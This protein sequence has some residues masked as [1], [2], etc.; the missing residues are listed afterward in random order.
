MDKDLMLSGENQL[1]FSHEQLIKPLVSEIHL[2]DTYVANTSL[3]HDKEAVDKLAPGVELTL[4]REVNKF[5]ENAI[6][7]VDS[8]G[9]KLGYIPEKD[10]VIFARLMDAGKLLVAKV[11]KVEKR[12]RGKYSAGDSGAEYSYCLISVGIYLKDY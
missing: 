5:E 10:T 4:R 2:F 9:V 6:A 1:A 12:G 7:V 8:N 11:T 3:N